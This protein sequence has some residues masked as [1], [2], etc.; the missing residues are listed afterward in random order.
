MLITNPARSFPYVES[1]K[2][3]ASRVRGRLDRRGG[4]VLLVTSVAENEGKSTLAANLA[5]ALSE[6]Q[7]RVLLL[8]CDFRQPALYKIFE[9]PQKAGKD[10][11]QVAVG[12]EP[13]SSVFEKYKD[14]NVYM[15]ICRERL[16]EPSE[17]VGGEIFRRI[18]DTCR[19]NMDYIILDTP[20]MGAAADAEELVELADGA[21]LAVRQDGVLTRDINDA[22]DALNQKEEKVIGCVFSNVYPGFGERIG[23]SYGYGYGYGAYSRAER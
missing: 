23:G 17:A 19:T 10:F 15:G 16:E 6:E 3:I 22:I 12:K 8:D 14:T 7:N 1:L 18:L 4:K 2:R 21:V 20:P 9:L 13:A 5:L 11:G